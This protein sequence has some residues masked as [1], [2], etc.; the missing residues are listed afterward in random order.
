MKPIRLYPTQPDSHGKGPMKARMMIQMTAQYGQ[1]AVQALLS[2]DRFKTVHT[3]CMFV[4]YP[5]SG[6]TLTGSLLDAHPHVIMG[7]EFDALR[8]VEHG[9][10]WKQ[11][12]HLI[13]NNAKN[14]AK[15]GRKMGGY[16]YP[17]PGQHQG[18]CE[19]P[20]VLGDKQG[21]KSSVTLHRRFE[22][23]KM[24]EQIVPCRFQIL[25]VIRNPYDNIATISLKSRISMEEAIASYRRKCETIFKLHDIYGPE[26]IIEE[27]HEYF[28]CNIREE[29]TR[30]C[31]RLGLVAEEG[32]LEACKSIV[33]SKPQTSRQKVEWTPAQRQTVEG[34]IAKYP[35]LA[36]YHFDE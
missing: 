5:R 25:T 6:H 3:F 8:Y 26:T 21:A 28:V 14:A 23:I 30:I 34:M 24:L 17:V 22:L 15:I 20:Y 33:F 31:G 4:G 11:I 12:S 16:E 1:S 36:G 9:F 18:R 29:L 27:K 13:E 32:Y 35:F 7:N 19:V 10:S 2:P